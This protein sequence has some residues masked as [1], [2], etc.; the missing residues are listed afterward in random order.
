[1]VYSFDSRWFVESQW[2]PSLVTRAT[3]NHKGVLLWY[4]VVC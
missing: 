3:M 4:E 1:M 2:C